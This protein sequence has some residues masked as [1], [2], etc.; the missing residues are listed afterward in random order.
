MG[1]VSEKLSRPAQHQSAP[2]QVGS[3]D[4]NSAKILY[5]HS[6]WAI[7]S[8]GKLWFSG[9]EHCQVT[10][11]KTR[12]ALLTPGY[13]EKFDLVWYGY[14]SLYSQ[15]PVSLERAIIAVHDPVELFPERPD[16]KENPVLK[17]EHRERLA[18]ARAVV[19]I[20]REMQ[21][22]LQRNG[23]SASRLPTR[24]TLPLRET[25]TIPAGQGFGFLS[26]GRIY[27]RKN[28]EQ[29][30]RIAA[31]LSKRGIP[32]YL[33][34]DHF[35]S[36]L[37]AY[38][39]LLDRYPVYVCTSF[40]EGG[41]LPVMDAMHRGAVPVSAPV[42]QALE[43]ISHGENGFICRTDDEFIDIVARL[44]ADPARLAELRRN[45]LASIASS[46]SKNVVSDSVQGFLISLLHTHPR[47]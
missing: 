24:S 39:R 7:E 36:G 41:P 19:V 12:S 15:H 20:S 9:Q 23:I 8:V 47:S 22:I 14:S 4:R 34:C 33:K 29:F 40:Q 21:E 18:K 5:I 17:P 43:I 31:P 26:V 11:L 2:A 45:A 6:G 30:R 3:S 25:A 27:R 37:P 42:G 44:A 16:W 1:L 46:R 13:L 10:F 38:L 28:F 32:S 35:A